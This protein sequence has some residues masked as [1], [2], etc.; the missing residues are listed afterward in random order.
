MPNTYLKR[1]ILVLLFAHA[2]FCFTHI[3]SITHAGECEY[4]IVEAWVKTQE[5]DWRNATVHETLKVH[6]PFEVKVK[7]I[8]KVNCSVFG[9]KIYGYGNAYEI[10]S[11]PGI[12]GEWFLEYNLSAGTER[13]YQWTVRPTGKFTEGEAPLNVRAQFHSKDSGN[14]KFVDFT[15]IAAYIEPEEWEEG[16]INDGGENN[17][18]SSGGGIPGF[19]IIVA[20]ASIAVMVGYMLRKKS[21]F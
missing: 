13:T 4:G 11:G 21:K 12:F 3:A 6:E 9:I 2:V 8:T 14:N 15:I 19:E 7:A 1:I 5:K 16:N 18:G 17:G 10:Q 20:I